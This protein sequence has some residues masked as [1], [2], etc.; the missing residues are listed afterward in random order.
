MMVVIN[1]DQCCMLHQQQQQAK[2]VFW[3]KDLDSVV[4]STVHSR[5]ELKEFI[6]T[7]TNAKKLAVV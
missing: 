7:P 3:T 1:C 2:N 5:F 6:T 4:K